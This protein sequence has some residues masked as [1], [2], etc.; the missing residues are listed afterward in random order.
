MRSV[1][2]LFLSLAL[3]SGCSTIAAP[4]EADPEIYTFGESGAVGTFSFT[5][6]ELTVTDKVGGQ[7][8]SG[9]FVLAEITAENIGKAPE[10]LYERN[11]IL[12]D[13][14]MREFQAYAS[15]IDFYMERF[16]G[17]INP[18]MSKT[19]QVAFEVPA[20]AEIIA[21][22]ASDSIIKYK[23]NYIYFMNE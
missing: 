3:L 14:E 15:Y 11:F 16:S 17:N 18:G 10:T 13:S 23:A 7:D 4:A 1:I 2:V 22:G 5:V 9:K 20:D 12:V 19:A 21:V 6:H 8:T